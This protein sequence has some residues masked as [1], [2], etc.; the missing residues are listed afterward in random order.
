LDRLDEKRPSSAA[1]F[2][3]AL[4]KFILAQGCYRAFFQLLVAA[5]GLLIRN[6]DLCRRKRVNKGQHQSGSLLIAQSQSFMLYF[7]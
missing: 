6:V 2:P 5:N 1:R 4:D 7:A 3:N